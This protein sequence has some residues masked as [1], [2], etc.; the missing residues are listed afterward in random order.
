PGP[1]VAPIAPIQPG[2]PIPAGRSIPPGS[3]IQS[4]AAGP[5]GHDGQ[6]PL[7][8]RSS[9]PIRRRLAITERREP[10]HRAPGR[11]HTDRS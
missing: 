2:Q 5:A 10:R 8:E 1:P 4:A 11:G 9:L 7:F 3:P 6:P